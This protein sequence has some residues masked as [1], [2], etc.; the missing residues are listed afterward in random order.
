MEKIRENGYSMPPKSS[1][2]CFD[3]MQ[4]I[5]KLIKDG[6][7]TFLIKE[8]IYLSIFCILFSVL[9]AFTV[10]PEHASFPM[11]TI[12]FLMGALTSILAGYIGMRIAVHANVRTTL[13][14]CDS[15]HSGFKVA[16][17]G[18]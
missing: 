7:I 3:L 5:A 17:R 10:E 6:A 13:S 12:A 18:G 2:D 1:E 15:V 9:L 16:F 8:Y 11:T 14:C 4:K